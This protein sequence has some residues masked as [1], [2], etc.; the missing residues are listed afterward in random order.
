[1]KDIM[2]EILKQPCDE[3]IQTIAAEDGALADRAMRGMRH[4]LKQAAA[5]PDSFSVIAFDKAE[6]PIGYALFIQS[7]EVAEE[8]FYTDL[9]VSEPYRRQGVATAVVK[10]GIGCLAQKQGRVLLCTVSPDNLPSLYLHRSLGFRRCRTKDFAF[11]KNDGL[12]MFKISVLP[13]FE[14]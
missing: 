7:A 3:V 4:I 12:Y 8:W 6:Q 9:W 11:F 1:M 2:L 13:F 10:R 14:E 5:Q